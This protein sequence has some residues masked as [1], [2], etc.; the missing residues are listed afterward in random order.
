MTFQGWGSQSS[1]PRLNGTTS[2][3]RWKKDDPIVGSTGKASVAKPDDLSSIPRTHMV[4]GLRILHIYLWPPHKCHN[5]A[6]NHWCCFCLFWFVC[7]VFCFC[8]FFSYCLFLGEGKQ[9]SAL[10][11]CHCVNK[12]TLKIPE[13][14]DTF[15]GGYGIEGQE[16]R[17]RSPGQFSC[18]S[19][20][21][22]TL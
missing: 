22:R 18:S 14:L 12:S 2:H 11:I 13:Y 6:V 7:F 15:D 9:I 20:H 5:Q 10:V 4:E 8:C 21:L 19:W 1:T 3:R 17:Q 16:M